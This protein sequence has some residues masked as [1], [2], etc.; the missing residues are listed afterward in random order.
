MSLLEIEIDGE[1]NE[2]LFFLPL[3]RR[4]VAGS[5]LT[6]VGNHSRGSSRASGPRRSRGNVSA[7]TSRPAKP[8]SP[9]RFGSRAIK[10][11]SKESSESE[12][13]VRLSS[14]SPM[15]ICRRG[16]SG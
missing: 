15:Y 4:I 13:L 6:G 11:R 16:C 12:R 1:L 7:S 8:M 9:N 5:I 3:Q 2:T 10:R 14:R